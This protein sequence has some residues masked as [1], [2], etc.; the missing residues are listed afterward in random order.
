MSSGKG[1]PTLLSDADLRVLANSAL[2]FEAIA[3]Q[4]GED[5]ATAVGILRDSD[6][7]ELTEAEAARLQPTAC[8]PYSNQAGGHIRTGEVCKGESRIK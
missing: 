1:Q 3:Q 6:T 8:L 7:H 4:H 5:V 2:S